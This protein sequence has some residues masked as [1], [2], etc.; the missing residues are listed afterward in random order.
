[1]NLHELFLKL[2][3]IEDDSAK[4]YDEFS[5]KCSEKLKPV[6][7]SFAAEE[8]QHKNFMLELFDDQKFKEKQL[9]E[10]SQ[11][12]LQQHLDFLQN[13]GRQL[14]LTSE[15]DFFQFSLQLEKNSIEMYTRQLKLFETDSDG[16]KRLESAI[17]DEKNHM[18]FIVNRLHELV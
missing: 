3:E 14:N 8:I 5:Q 2:A 7:R 6:A 11:M 17:R 13:T 12:I 4:L 1:M 15:K 16:Y 9:D 10:S 18:I